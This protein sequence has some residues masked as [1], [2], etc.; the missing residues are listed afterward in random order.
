M[1]LLDGQLWPIPVTL[2]V[3]HD[4]PSV[5]VGESISL[6]DL[7]GVVLAILEVETKFV[8]NKELE[9]LKVF[10][11]TDLTHPAV[12]Y[13]FNFAGDI[14]LGGTITGLQFPTYYDFRALRHTPNE[15]RAVFN[16][17]GWSKIV[18]FQTNPLHR[19]HQELTFR[20]AKGG[21]CKFANTSC[22]R[23]D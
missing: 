7:E 1:R 10:G 21:K 8:P 11:T 14:Y 9:A 6:C 2:D 23:H 15:L 20:A 13:L 22:C 17:L 18:A 3:S 12:N 5:A 16:K 4:F 19:A